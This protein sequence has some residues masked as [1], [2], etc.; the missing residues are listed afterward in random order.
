MWKAVV[1]SAR[2]PTTNY[3]PK[4]KLKP[5]RTKALL[6]HTA[7]RHGYHSKHHR[8]GTIKAEILRH[9]HGWARYPSS[10][11]SSSSNPTEPCTQNTQP[12]TTET[13]LDWH[14]G[15]HIEVLTVEQSSTPGTYSGRREPPESHP[16]LARAHTLRKPKGLH[17]HSL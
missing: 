10:V 14:R 17:S 16:A 4:S 15:R 12:H 8:P 6:Q 3:F 7:Q 2:I 1:L 9:R 5:G 13:F 11:F